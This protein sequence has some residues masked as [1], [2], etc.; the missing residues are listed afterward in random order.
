MTDLSL[1]GGL[2]TVDIRQ[3]RNIKTVD[4]GQLWSFMVK[5]DQAERFRND[6]QPK[7]TIKFR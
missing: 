5:N 4:N 6:F 2:I 7:K 3:Y 1:G